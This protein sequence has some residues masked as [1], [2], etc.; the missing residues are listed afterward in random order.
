MRLWF[1]E[2]LTTTLVNLGK[3]SGSGIPTL[4][5]RISAAGYA[6]FQ[7]STAVEGLKNVAIKYYIASTVVYTTCRYVRVVLVRRSRLSRVVYPTDRTHHTSLSRP[8]PSASA[9]L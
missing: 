6:N 1:L 8:A 4:V 2:V 7:N 5:Y 9:P 3:T